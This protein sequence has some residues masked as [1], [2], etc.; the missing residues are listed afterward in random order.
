MRRNIYRLSL[1]AALTIASVGAVSGALGFYRLFACAVALVVLILPIQTHLQTRNLIEAGTTIQNRLK[2]Y[3][4]R[5]Q[6]DLISRLSQIAEKVARNSDSAAQ[7]QQCVLR[8]E[9]EKLDPTTVSSSLRD[10]FATYFEA[11]NNGVNSATQAAQNVARAALEMGDLANRLVA[12]TSHIQDSSDR[13]SE[14]AKRINESSSLVDLGSL[15]NELR[16][17]ARMTRLV[18]HQLRSQS[19]AT[20]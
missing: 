6:D 1:L 16:Q 2:Q 8:M 17:E 5:S 14:I 12:T 19:H 10:Q 18:V 4:G 20:A 9:K 15:A 7:I 13:I 3:H 11:S